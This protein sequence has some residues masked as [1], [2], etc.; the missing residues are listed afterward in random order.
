VWSAL[1]DSVPVAVIAP[2]L[3]VIP[4]QTPFNPFD[5]DLMQTSLIVQ[6]P[7]KSPP[8]GVNVGHVESVLVVPVPLVP[9][10]E[11]A[12]A[13]A[14]PVEPDAPLPRPPL[15]EAAAA[16]APPAPGP[17]D[18]PPQAQTSTETKNTA[19]ESKTQ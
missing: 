3:K 9:A 7:S 10:F 2:T 12:L 15:P 4:G 1:N 18:E 11:I 17:S 16:L 5:G 19:L 6:S 13:P 14:R 8:Q